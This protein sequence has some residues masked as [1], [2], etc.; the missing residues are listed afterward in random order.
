MVIR[1]TLSI[2]ALL[3]LA[4]PPSF[5]A[6]GGRVDGTPLDSGPSIDRM[7]ETGVIGALGRRATPS[8]GTAS[9]DCGGGVMTPGNTPCPPPDAPA[10]PVDG[11]LTLLALAGAGYATR[12]LKARSR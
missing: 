11:G 8:S 9:R 1:L 10:V 6:D 12:K 4:A 2:F 5:A 7:G 3:L